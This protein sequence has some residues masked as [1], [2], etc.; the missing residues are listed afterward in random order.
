MI[1]RN[2]SICVAGAFVLFAA[3]A[4][5][6]IMALTHVTIVDV[7]DGS[8]R[9]DQTL[10]IKDGVISKIGAAGAVK[11]PAG[12][13]NVDGSGKFLIPGL[14]DMHVH[15]HREARWKYHYPL[16]LAYGVVGVRDAGSHLGS[17]LAAMEWTKT[18]P[19][20]PHVIWGSPIIDGAPQINSFGLSAE[21]AEAARILVREM[22]KY[23]FDFVKSYDRL[24]P[25]AYFALADEA[26]K[27][28]IPLEGHVPLSL[29]PHDVIAAGQTVIDH[30]TL[31]VE[32]CS[33][34]ALAL[35][36]AAYA[37]APRE[38]ESLAFLMDEK[39]VDVFA[40]VDM[41]SCRPLF[42]DFAAHQVWHVPTLIQMHGFFRADEPEVSS[43]PRIA[44][45]TPSL[46]AEWKEWSET[47]DRGE[48]AIGKKAL[49]AQM[50]SIRAL[51]D[52]GVGLLAGTDASS[53]SFVF[54]GAGVHD[55]M[56][57]M[58][59]AGLTPL[60]ALQTATINPLRYLGRKP[61]APVI[62]K[63]E[64]ADLVLLDADPLA[65]IANTTKISGVFAHR[66]F[67]D[68]AALDALL[69]LAKA[70]AAKGAN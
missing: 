52:A 8:R 27:Q 59:E 32:G 69:D 13:E 58:V 35:I 3:P 17:A 46:A 42:N 7:E 5:A 60:E 53:E 25:E 66:D 40:D 44:F 2:L 29:T 61:G 37:K 10:I 38:A 47:T 62:S 6:A 31:V 33:P 68:R 54:A 67:F 39:I 49:A 65:D 36:H 23:G 26:K 14:W 1:V 22:K 11:I 30:L 4:E 19:I 15:S 56:K 63:G 55:E 9:A 41:A 48:L 12:A 16:F 21:D 70:E 43:D 34:E 24:T 18:N 64:A 20:A 57:L 45:T 51:E 50:R 28:K